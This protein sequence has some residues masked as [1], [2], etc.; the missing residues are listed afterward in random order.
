MAL[1]A[2]LTIV[3]VALFMAQAW[4]APVMSILGNV[5]LILAP[6]ASIVSLSCSPIAPE[7]FAAFP[8]PSTLI[9]LGYFAIAIGAVASLPMV[10]Q[11]STFNNYLVSEVLIAVGALLSGAAGIILFVY[12]AV[13]RRQ[14]RHAAHHHH[15]HHHDEHTRP[16]TVLYQPVDGA[17]TS[18]PINAA[19]M[20]VAYGATAPGH[21]FVYSEV[22]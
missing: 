17:Y 3:G 2:N 19:P 22:K 11:A 13:I 10:F 14:V 1:S 18:A 4:L 8:F 20:P 5:V 21:T 6:F 9:A 7:Q 12:V 16:A 15:H